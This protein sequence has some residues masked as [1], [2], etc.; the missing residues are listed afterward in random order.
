M[1][2]LDENRNPDST[3]PSLVLTLL[4]AMEQWAIFVDKTTIKRFGGTIRERQP[5]SSNR[6]RLGL[7]LASQYKELCAVTVGRLVEAQSS[8]CTAAAGPTGER[9]GAAATR[10]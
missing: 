8:P 5:D 9:S 2:K 1:Q 7:C 10:W 3:R 4:S 6:L